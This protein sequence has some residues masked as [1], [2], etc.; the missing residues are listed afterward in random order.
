MFS[1]AVHV[2]VFLPGAHEFPLESIFELLLL[3][4]KFAVVEVVLTHIWI[5]HPVLIFL[6]HGILVIFLNKD[7]AFPFELLE[8]GEKW[9]VDFLDAVDDDCNEDVIGAGAL[10]DQ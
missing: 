8:M 6:P 4:Q 10:F 3:E 5:D 1:D 2:V 7:L 9:G